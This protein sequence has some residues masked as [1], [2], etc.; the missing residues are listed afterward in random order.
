MV[1]PEPVVIAEPIAEPVEQVPP[2][3]ASEA[4]RV[5]LD[6]I[7]AAQDLDALRDVWTDAHAMHLLGH[8]IDG[9]ILDDHIEAK[10]VDLERAG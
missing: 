8:Q 6:R 2:V 9:Q 7:D 1:E 10:R 4:A 5:L 3:G